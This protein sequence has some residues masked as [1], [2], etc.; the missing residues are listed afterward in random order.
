MNKKKFNLN[1]V[2][3]IILLL[4][5]SFMLVQCNKKDDDLTPDEWLDHSYAGILSVQF[6]LDYPEV[7]AST[8]MDVLIDKELGA[9]QISSGSLSFEGETIIEGDAKITRSGTW[10]FYPTGYLV[11][12]DNPAVFIDGGL[13][14]ENDVQKIYA[15]DEHGAW[16]LVST[17]HYDPAEPNADLTFNLDEAVLG[18][19]TVTA[20]GSPFSWLWKLDLTVGLDK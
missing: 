11:N 12:P 15:K 20:A 18:G 7:T 9:V 10:S 17:I 6:T 16:Q 14:I 2:S 13:V 4:L 8:T 1:P 3:R 5:L 19:A